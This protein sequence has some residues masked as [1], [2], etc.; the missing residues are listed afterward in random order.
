MDFSTVNK[1]HFY[2]PK[3]G[4]AL[5]N[6]IFLKI[7]LRKLFN[8]SNVLHDYCM[9]SAGATFKINA[10]SSSKWLGWTSQCF[11]QKKQITSETT[12]FGS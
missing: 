12:R 2:L 5:W 11:V 3:N 6:H 9:D 1:C 7:F 10:D 8:V 4:A